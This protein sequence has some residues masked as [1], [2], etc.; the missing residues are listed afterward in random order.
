M[1][2]ERSHYMISKIRTWQ[3][4]QLIILVRPEAPESLLQG[5]KMAGAKGANT[6]NNGC[7][8]NNGC[9]NSR[10]NSPNH[11]NLTEGMAL[12]QAEIRLV[13]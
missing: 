2:R 10:C 12:H 1:F 11:R 4:P 9:N 8:F 3:K 13:I 6:R 7:R 5:C